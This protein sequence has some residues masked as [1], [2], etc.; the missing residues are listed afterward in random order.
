MKDQREQKAYLREIDRKDYGIDTAYR[1]TWQEEDIEGLINYLQNNNFDFLEE[2]RPLQLRYE[3][4]EQVQ[5]LVKIDQDQVYMQVHQEVYDSKE[6]KEKGGIPLALQGV[7]NKSE[8]V[9]LDSW[10]SEEV[11]DFLRSRE[12]IERQ[13]YDNR[14]GVPIGGQPKE[15]QL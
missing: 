2:E 10:L 9:D 6:Q 15:Y 12:E 13:N 8:E 11:P 4:E 7:L 1:M 3:D 5:A 14:E